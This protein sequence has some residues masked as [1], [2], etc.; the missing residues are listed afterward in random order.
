MTSVFNTTALE[1]LADQIVAA[2]I[3]TIDGDIVGDG[4]RYDDE[5]RVEEVGDEVALVGGC[6][7]NALQQTLR[8]LLQPRCCSVRRFHLVIDDVESANAATTL[9]RHG[10]G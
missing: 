1:P 5:F 8:L 6:R 10:D 2:G 7:E 3:T 4:S 9:R